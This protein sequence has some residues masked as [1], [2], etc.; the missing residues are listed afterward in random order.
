MRGK[1]LGAR[2]TKVGLTIVVTI[3]VMLLLS[4]SAWASPPWSDATNAWWL[5]TYSISE[6]QAA[7]V[8]DGWPDGTFRPN[9]QVNRAQFAKMATAGLGV[10]TAY[11]ASPSFPDVP[12]SNYFYPWIEGGHQ[13]GLI[14]GQSDGTFGPNNSIIRQQA[15]SILGNYLAQREL[16]LRG[17]LAGKTAN[18]PSL[19]TWY[20]A[21]GQSILAQ[22][23]DANRVAAVHAPATAY[24]IYRGVVQGS[25]SNGNMYLGPGLDLTRAQ[26]VALI[27]RVKA[28]TF[29][30]ALPTI[31]SLNPSSGLPSGG[32]T[33]IITGANFTE[34]F[35]VKFGTTAAT[36]TVNSATQ[37]TAVAPAGAIGTVDVKVETAAGTSA[38]S[39]ASKYNYGLPILTALNPGS[40]PTSGG[41]TV[42]I[43]GTNLSG[44]TAVKFGTKPAVSFNVVSNTQ[45][46]AVAPSGTGTVDVTVTAPG[47]T[48]ATS[49]AS[50][51]S[52]GPP[53]VTG[54][55]PTTGPALGGNTVIITGTGFTGVTSVYF[56]DKA[57][58]SY[59]VTSPT[60]ISAVAPSNYGGVTVDVKVT[61]GGG[62]S[63]VSNASKYYYGGPVITALTPN[64]GPT[65]AGTTVIITG[66]GFTGVTAVYFGEKPAVSYVVNSSTQITA[67]APSGTAGQVV[68][69]RVVTTSG[70]S[71]MSAAT[72]YT[73]GTSV[74]GVVPNHG[75]ASGGNTV[76]IQGGGFLAATSVNFGATTILPANFTVNATGTTITLLAP[77]GTGKVDIRVNIGAVKSANT[78]ADDYYYAP[79]I[80]TMDPNH[81]P[82]TGGTTVTIVGTGFTNATAVA[83]GG[84]YG[85]ALHVFSDTLLTV[86]TPSHAAGVVQVKVYGEYDWSS[87]AGLENDFT[88]GAPVITSLSPDHGPAAGGNN[89]IINGAGFTDATSVL[90]GGTTILPANFTVNAAGTAITVQAPNGGGTVDVRVTTADG[91]S[92]NTAADDYSYGPTVTSLSPTNGSTAGGYTVAINGT[93]F[94]GAT[95]VNFAGTTISAA[96]FV[97]HTA[98]KIEVTAPAKAAGTYDVRVNTPAGTSP[99]TAADD[100]TYQAGPP[101]ITNLNPISGPTYGGT[102]V[103]ITGTNFT[104]ATQITIGGNNLA[105]GSLPTGFVVNGTGTTITFVTPAHSAGQVDVTV[106]RGVDS[107]TA[108]NAYEYLTPV[109]TSRGISQWREEGGTWTTWSGATSVTL[110]AGTFIELRMQILD[111]WGEPLDTASAAAKNPRFHWTPSDDAIAPDSGANTDSGG[112]VYWLHEGGHTDATYAI[113]LG[114]DTNNDKVVDGGESWSA[115]LTITWNP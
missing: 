41:N 14:A 38:A 88:Y 91:T 105:P 10:A 44:A 59:T 62:T 97:S 85:T 112:Y 83:F 33:V 67:S 46:T 75:P 21:E 40:G 29:S 84:S 96:S 9:L 27:L 19:N 47:G 60:Q 77:A 99:N 15:N 78:T 55:S 66:T 103:V 26:A 94:T 82:T 71:G 11:P 73:Y 106:T 56:G 37:I 30:T 100:F 2:S 92:A 111:Q 98:T 22:Y 50:K 70:T 74:T 107:D 113:Q 76:V 31:V 1:A 7:T 93:D 52:Y 48:T 80:T 53:T 79:V 49:A 63:A 42:I 81:G 6:S 90:F 23:A 8:A 45:I 95:S 114:F 17:H 5:S 61:T 24:L 3:V 109:A 34:V 110:D 72:K 57:A 58:T 104:G 108:T 89:V 39:T 25:Y 35:S 101:S 13:A 64:A 54:L 12:P 86:K 28:V 87:T 68:D 69:V 32:N 51:Y 16:N 43:T 102:T 36:F 4:S 20:V 115:V 65:T 18:Y